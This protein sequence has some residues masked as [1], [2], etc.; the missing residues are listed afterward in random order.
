MRTAYAAT[1]VVLTTMSHGASQAPQPAGRLF[2]VI[3]NV[4]DMAT[5][6]RFWRDVMGFPVVYPER[7]ADLYKEPFVRLEAGGASLVLHSGRTT[8][9]QNQ[10]P[11]LS[12]MTD[13]LGETRA[14]L[15]RLGVRLSVIR[16]PA[17]GVFVVDGR[18]P[19][20]NVFHLEGREPA[21]TSRGY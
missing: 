1:M 15:L 21:A 16:S 11:R 7:S 17:P 20:G 13:A 10:E 8:E 18:D 4:R 3:L 5:Q 2:Q 12:F 19:E 6:L 9:N 14:R